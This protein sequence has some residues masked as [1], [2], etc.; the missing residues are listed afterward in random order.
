M[1]HKSR[2]FKYQC[3]KCNKYINTGQSFVEQ[4]NNALKILIDKYEKL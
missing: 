4:K 2:S 3:P 1:I